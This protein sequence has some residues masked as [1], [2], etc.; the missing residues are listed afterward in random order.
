[1]TVSRY[2]DASKYIIFYIGPCLFMIRDKVIDGRDDDE[3]VKNNNNLN[4]V[5]TL[6][7]CV[8]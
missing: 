8:L 7:K 5:A 4:N 2:T 3:K 6:L 1:M